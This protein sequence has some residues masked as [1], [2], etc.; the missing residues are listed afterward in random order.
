MPTVPIMIHGKEVPVT[1]TLQEFQA[2]LRGEFTGVTPRGANSEQNKGGTST[3]IIQKQRPKLKQVM[4]Y[5]ESQPTLDI[6]PI[7]IQ[8]FFF[9]HQLNSKQE[10]RMYAALYGIIARAKKYIEKK[11]LGHYEREEILR[12]KDGRN[13]QYVVMRFV[14]D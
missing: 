8:E 10:S 9:G 14:K 1:F 3:A 7:A 12:E 5:I 6:D 13:R 11:R 2:Y 4:A